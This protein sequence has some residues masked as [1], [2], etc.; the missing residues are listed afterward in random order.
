MMQIQGQQRSNSNQLH[1]RGD[2]MSED[3]FDDQ[4][5]IQQQTSSKRM[6]YFLK[7]RHV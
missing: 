2:L 5:W 7:V 1:R 3:E 6:N 4:Q